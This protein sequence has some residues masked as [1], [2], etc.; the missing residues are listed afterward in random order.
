MGAKMELGEDESKCYYE[1]DRITPI[2]AIICRAFLGRHKPR[3]AMR[4]V[5]SGDGVFIR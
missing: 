2:I 3:R 5:S 4:Q 1:N